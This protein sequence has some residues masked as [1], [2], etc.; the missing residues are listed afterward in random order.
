MAYQ[1][2]YRGSF[3]SVAGV[4][5][6]VEIQTVSETVTDIKE[7]TFDG[8]EPVKIDWSVEDK[9]TVIC[10]SSATI[11]IESPG[12]RTYAHLYTIKPGNVRC[13]IYRNDVLYWTGC[14]DPE[15]YEEPYERADK[16][17][18]TLTFSDFGILSRLKYDF[19]A[20]T[21]K[22]L[23][24]LCSTAVSRANIPTNSMTVENH[25]TL[26]FADGTKSALSSLVV[27]SAN[28]YDEDGEPST[29]EEVLEGVLQPLA[30]KIVQKQGR[31]FIYDLN[32]LYNNSTQQEI[33]WTGASQT[34]SVDKVIS[35][36]TVT[37]SP[38]TPDSI[39][40]PTIDSDILKDSTSGVTFG[41][42]NSNNA[43]TDKDEILL[44][45]FEIRHGSV[46]DQA[47]QLSNGAEFFRI[48]SGYSGSDE[49]G[50]AA[51]YREY[52]T[53]QSVYRDFILG[54]KDVLKAYD[55]NGKIKSKV[56]ATTPGA[57]ITA[58]DSKYML[59]IELSV[60]FDVRYNPFE[61]A[62]LSNEEGNWDKQ[63]NWCNFGYIPV[64]LQLKN[65]GGKV[66]YHYEN[67]KT[68]NSDGYSTKG[69]WVAGDGSW[70]C[71]FLSYYDWEDRKSSS[72]F[73]GWSTNKQT[74]GYY[75]DT[76]PSSWQKRGNGEFIEM[77]PAK[78][79]LVLQI[80]RGVHQF[81]YKREVKDI[82]DKIRWLLYK[83]PKVTL[84]KRNGLSV[85]YHDYEYSSYINKDAEE[86]LSID[87][88]CGTASEN[89]PTARG[90]YLMNDS[91]RL[92]IHQFQR[93]GVTDQL[94]NLL[95]STLYSQYAD[96]KIVLSGEA[97]LVTYLR[98]FTEAN[99]G[100]KLFMIK[101]EQQNLRMDTS[102]VTLVEFNPDEYVPLD[103]VE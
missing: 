21:R 23:W 83:D 82:Y 36:A 102:D 53:P 10:A 39:I 69:E 89:L 86:E 81:D 18:V 70:G 92:Q 47:L 25:T 61:T 29:W 63:Q 2:I 31:P 9:E 68:V 49:V 75:R 15:Q 87:T 78:G 91:S 84:V 24:T 74:I 26:M 14:L 5:W 6:K 22:N 103:P 94:E 34:M 99:Q 32:G 1:T 97:K 90:C 54:E 48:I 55:D 27:E 3:L 77:P 43:I 51:A 19:D 17:N 44:A 35:S 98:T 4:T 76:L 11:I 80:G 101:G 57:P 65:T 60:L 59:K 16:Y 52:R 45:G 13:Q 12:D 28:F 66:L 50:F 7:L 93:G 73:N 46:S 37:F 58:V 30:M 100:D 8:D 62:A 79:T 88:I 42:D 85:D 95:L 41:V 64:M 72:G 56:I 38:Y 40:D 20:D 96:R 71:M 67:V 33:Y